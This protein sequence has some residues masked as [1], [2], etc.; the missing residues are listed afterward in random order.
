MARI[1]SVKPEFWTD[2]NMIGLTPWARLFYIGTWNFALCDRGHLPDDPLG[3]KLK[4]LPADSVDAHSIVG[5]L[6]ANRRLVRRR[7][8]GRTYL[9]IPRLGDHQ[10]VDTRWQSRCPHCASE[11]A[12]GFTEDSPELTET[13]ASSGEPHESPPT[14]AVTDS[15]PSLDRRVIGRDGIGEEVPPTAGAVAPRVDSTD[16]LVAEW[17]QHCRKRPPNSVI[18]QVGKQV[19]ALLAEGVD[20]TDV[21]AGL[22]AWHRKGVHPSVLP[23]M[24][25]ELMNATPARASPNGKPSTTD[26]RVGQALAIAD[27]LERLEIEP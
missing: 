4:I 20:S 17:L 24:V 15:N 27:E 1:R 2:G 7:S 10:K 16:S 14:R 26:S 6:L 19:K 22:A 12:E 23:S 13:R 21:R 18:G 5:E 25:N 3:L 8:G 11:E 9:F